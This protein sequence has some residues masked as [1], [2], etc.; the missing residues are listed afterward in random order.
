M[1]FE[2][3]LQQFVSHY[4]KRWPDAEVREFQAGEFKVLETW[5]PSQLRAAAGNYPKIFHHGRM[6][7]HVVVLIHG[8]TDSPFYMQAIAQDF[9]RL[10][11]TVVLPL[12]PAHGLRRPGRAFRKLK[13]T[14]WTA[15]VDAICAISKQLGN[16][17]SLGGLSTGGALAVHKTIRDPKTVTGGLFLFS[18]ALDI[19]TPEQMLL[20]TEA[21]RIIGRFK[22]RGAWFRKA[23]WEK[24]RTIRAD[25]QAGEHKR[26]YGIGK[27]PYKYSVFFYEGVSQLAEIIQEINRHYGDPFTKF[28]DIT[29]PVFAAHSESDESALIKG[30]RQLIDHHPNEATRLF[31]LKDVGHGNVVLKREIKGQFAPDD[32]ELANPNYEEM[33]QAMLKFVF[34]H[35]IFNT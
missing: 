3:G 7:D 27:N 6:T 9:V 24:I 12:L 14:D 5:S 25:Q 19:G 26:R 4:A 15:E 35:L 31:V 22:D 8:L 23:F 30:I 11:F 33:S 34:E 32:R 1:Q 29:Q 28:R 13:H 17:L 10:G 18:A 21:G 20:Q 16:I 2:Q